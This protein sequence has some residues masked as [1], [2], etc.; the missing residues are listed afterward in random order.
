[1]ISAKI[2][3]QVK[4]SP[5]LTRLKFPDIHSQILEIVIQYLHFKHLNRGKD[6][7]PQFTIDP[8]IACDVLKAAT[9]LEC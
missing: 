8:R 5:K 2:R 1:M 6:N 9:Y 4:A 3:T 7:P